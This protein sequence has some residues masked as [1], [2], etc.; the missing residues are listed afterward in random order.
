MFRWRRKKIVEECSKSDRNW[1]PDWKNSE[2]DAED[3]A[4]GQWIDYEDGT[5][6]SGATEKNI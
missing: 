1:N 5:V 6:E 2:R 4:N 3:S